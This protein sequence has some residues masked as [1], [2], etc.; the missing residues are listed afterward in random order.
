MIAHLCQLRDRTVLVSTRSSEAW[1]Y[2]ARRD[3]FVRFLPDL[4]IHRFL[5]ESDSLLWL[6]CSSK[7]GMSFIAAVDRRTGRCSVYPRQDPDS[8]SHRDESVSAMCMDDSGN[9]WYGTRGGGLIRFDVKQKTYRRYAANPGSENALIANSV[10]ALI[11]DSAGRLWVGTGAGLTLMDC[12]RGT[13]E[14]LHNS[15]VEDGERD[16]PV[17]GR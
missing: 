14:H 5:E 8:A 17:H 1:T 6:G 7:M 4:R 15:L 12:D 3:T 16:D 9:L 2:V 13:F 11:P 10:S